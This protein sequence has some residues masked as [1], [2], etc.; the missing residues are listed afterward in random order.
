MSALPRIS[1]QAVL[2]EEEPAAVDESRGR[3][4]VVLQPFEQLLQYSYLMRFSLLLWLA[5]VLLTAADF[6][7]PSAVTRGIL[8][9]AGS[10]QWTF[11]GF[12][13]VLSGWFALLAARLV[14]AYGPDRFGAEI[15][16]FLAVR[17]Q[18]RTTVFL[19][20]QAPGLLL[21]SRIAY[22]AVHEQEGGASRVLFFLACGAFAGL[23]FWHLIA[24]LYYWMYDP[25]PNPNRA[26][27]AFLVPKWKF[28]PLEELEHLPPTMFL[29]VLLWLIGGLRR[30]GPGYE[31]NGKLRPGHLIV[32]LTLGATVLLYAICL[33][34]SAPVPL[35]IA[36]VIVGRFSAVMA[37]LVVWLLV[38]PTLRGSRHLNARLAMRVL[39][40]VTSL[41]LFG[42][43]VLGA[44]QPSAPRVIPVIA[45]VA[46]L[47]T[48]FFWALAGVAFWADRFRLPVLTL[49]GLYLLFNNFFPAEHTFPAARLSAEQAVAVLPVPASYVDRLAFDE[50]G[51]PKPVIVVTA[52]GGGIHAAAWTAT[53]LSQ[54][55]EQFA[56]RR[57]HNH[58][59]L[60][61][62]VSGGSVASM[63]YMREYLGKQPF[64]GDRQ[65]MQ[66]VLGA[67]QCS[68]L[69]AVAWGL[70]YPDALRLAFPWAFELAPSL[71]RFDR[72]WALDQALERNLSDP[73]C[74]G[75]G[76]TVD[77]TK[78]SES[79]EE[80]TLNRLTTIPF[81]S[82]QR[83][84]SE[85]AMR[86]LPAFTFNST[87]AETGDRF[88]LSNYSVRHD[89][90]DLEK[91]LPAASFLG[92]FGREAPVHP[93]IGGRGGFADLSLVTAARLSA[94]FTYVSPA[95]RLPFE[96]S[97]GSN[98]NA[99]H[100]VDG[101]YY[102]N[103]GT[104]SVIEFL[105]SAIKQMESSKA[106]EGRK[107][108]V[109]LIEIRNGDDL[110]SY[111]SPD[112]YAHQSGLKYGNHGWTPQ[113]DRQRWGAMDQ[114]IAPE[115][116]ALNAG[117]GSVTRRN[118]RELDILKM[119]YK[120]RLDLQHL[121]ID[122]QKASSE[123]HQPLS[124]HLTTRQQGWISGA[125]QG[126][127]GR[128]CSEQD[129]VKKAVDWFDGKP[130]DPGFNASSCPLPATPEV[131]VR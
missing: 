52:T 73:V 3:L 1:D 120:D 5:M 67:S 56:E 108:R 35:G 44:A 106:H 28:L 88:L 126:S 109:L 74:V 71:K 93:P 86:H 33:P 24:V 83:Y 54:L 102:D 79:G 66:R 103:D 29:H 96:M 98:R 7:S 89:D 92:V 12:T 59:L 27:R 111:D 45:Y 8:T 34:I 127:K 123:M 18:M 43:F 116:A 70:T 13:V 76:K 40:V 55:E 15:P 99:Y 53:V 75:S 81:E 117:L 105:N 36:R 41:L 124:W 22:N 121:V 9:P 112:S 46:L 64:G 58:L 97:Q 65:S 51:E 115:E 119:A 23:V 60:I 48:V 80:L 17:D 21:L 104:S 78:R 37:A 107:L 62:S 87:V 125:M 31:L 69:Q 30:L 128:R 25:D 14:C 110:D 95:A 131:A 82:K 130:M 118:R 101:G 129:Q 47:L 19:G 84:A 50:A 100:F 32:M 85:N 20:A 94:T 39:P 91:D 122:Y 26:A 57:F 49:V 72:G 42:L 11:T 16:R 63:A 114:A 61:S 4:A 77:G 10:W 90:Q 38:V 2:R 113:A 6:W 68:S